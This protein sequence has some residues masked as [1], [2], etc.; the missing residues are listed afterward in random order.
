MPTRTYGNDLT[1]LQRAL[2]VERTNA[3]DNATRLAIQQYVSMAAAQ[4]AAARRSAQANN[5]ELQRQQL[6]QQGTYQQGQLGNQARSIESEALNRQ[7]QT[8]FD[9]TKFNENRDYNN[10]LLALREQQLTQVPPSVQVEQMRNKQ[11]EIDLANAL[12]NAA[13]TMNQNR[14][15][16]KQLFDLSRL[17]EEANQLG[18][19]P[20]A[21]PADTAA[22]ADILHNRFDTNWLPFKTSQIGKDKAAAA[23]SALFAQMPAGYQ[24]ETNYPVAKNLDLARKLFT[25]NQALLAPSVQSV[26]Q[27]GLIDRLFLSPTGYVAL[28]TAPMTSTSTNAVAPMAS[29]MFTNAPTMTS[30]NAVA[31]TNRVTVRTPDGKTTGTVPVQRVNDYLSRG[32]TL[33]L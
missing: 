12:Q 29:G 26:A 6:A 20:T 22:E 19:G 17:E 30:T 24:K 16:A 27:Q 7:A 32:Y 2:T 31:A 10:R 23:I 13:G 9:Q 33:V 28:G 5:N 14:D 15:V 25:S 4:A 1:D 18:I 3:A 8:L 11:D 21:N